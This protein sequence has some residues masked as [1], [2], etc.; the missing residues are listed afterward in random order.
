M[1]K[2]KLLLSLVALC[3]IVGMGITSC[4]NEPVQ[5]PQG[6]QGPVGPQG[7]AGENGENG[8]DG[9]LILHGEGKPAD[10]LGKDSDI[11]ID[12]KTGD[13]YQKENG[14]WT[15]VM[16]IKGEGGEDGKDGHDGLN[17]AQGNPGETAYSST[18][19]P[20]TNG[21]V[22]VNKGSAIANGKDTIIFTIDPSDGYY[23]SSFSLNGTPI[24]TNDSKLVFNETSKTYTYETT[25]VKNGFVVSATFDNKTS[26]ETTYIDGKPYSGTLKDPYGHIF[27][28]GTQ[29]SSEPSFS[30][31]SGTEDDPLLLTESNDLTKIGKVDASYFKLQNNIEAVNFILSTEEDSTNKVKVIDLNDNEIDFTS[32]NSVM[33]I[34]NGLDVTF[35]NGVIGSS[36]GV[37]FASIGLGSSKSKTIG[38]NL[39]IENVTMNNLS[40]GIVIE[41]GDSNLNIINSTI[42][43]SLMPVSTN[44][45]LGEQFKNVKINIEGSKLIST[46]LDYGDV[47]NDGIGL[48]INTPVDV[49]VTDSYIEGTRQA[50]LVRGGDVEIKDSTICFSNTF[51][52]NPN[53]FDNKWE[54]G[55]E[56]AYS[57]IVVGDTSTTAYNYPANLTLSNVTYTRVPESSTNSLSVTS[58]D[59]VENTRTEPYDIYMFG[60]SKDYSAT[61]NIDSKTLS[62]FSNENIYKNEYSYIKVTDDANSKTNAFY[63]GQLYST[64]YLYENGEPNE[65]LSTKVDGVKFEDGAGTLA[66][67][68]KVKTEEQFLLLNGDNLPEDELYLQLTGDV[69]LNSTMDINQGLRHIDLNGHT[70]SINKAASSEISDKANIEIYSSATEKGKIEYIELPSGDNS[71]IKVNAGATLNLDNISYSAKNGAA[72]WVNQNASKLVVNNSDI[73]G[74]GYGICTN[75]GSPDNYNVTV[76]ANDSKIIGSKGA[77]LLFNIPGTCIMNNCYIMGDDQAVIARG[78]DIELNTCTLS[79]KDNKKSY[80]TDYDNVDWASGN[81]VPVA[82]IVLGNRWNANGVESYAY[83]KNLS[84]KNITFTPYE[85][86]GITSETFIGNEY[87]YAY[88]TSKDNNEATLVID[89]TTKEFLDNNSNRLFFHNVENP[90]KIESVQNT[91]QTE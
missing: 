5:G 47:E 4:N 38:G 59:D 70:L 78:G 52:G 30:G 53:H 1:Q 34:L 3:S 46:G 7:P 39:T 83:D 61:L 62:Q 9:S 76:E 25:M 85:G 42:N 60:E 69:I 72:I 33:Q 71:A 16:N 64:L 19:L 91:E 40:S 74:T 8:E 2:R 23:L 68:L 57:G 87:I 18:I 10:S 75:A 50:V 37:D 24:E 77:G 12:S 35:K 21:F 86:T 65:N 84:L 56:V 55:N 32:S 11:Y 41:Y 20:S 44:A 43:A 36:T 80:S 54:T 45:S 73:S 22:T 31:G 49:T 29:D 28:V 67:P 17:G 90:W 26:T 48:L 88:M 89:D 15:L 66:D 14:S 63:K 58:E 27:N 6:E 82:Y 13:L 79:I 81:G 51:S